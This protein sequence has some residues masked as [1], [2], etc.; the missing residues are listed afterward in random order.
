ME[1]AIRVIETF[2]ALTSSGSEILEGLKLPIGPT[3]QVS[4]GNV[5]DLG[6]LTNAVIGIHAGTEF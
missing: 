5:S 1:G 2:R 4:L 3:E 6:D